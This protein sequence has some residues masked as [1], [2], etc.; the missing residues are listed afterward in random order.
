MKYC[1]DTRGFEGPSIGPHGTE[2]RQ[3]LGT[4]DRC[5]NFILNTFIYQRFSKRI[6]SVDD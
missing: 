1:R 6:L 5:R 4:L 3:P 2:K